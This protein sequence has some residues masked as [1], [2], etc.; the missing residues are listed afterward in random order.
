M[1][2]LPNIYFTEF[3]S[4]HHHNVTMSKCHNAM[5]AG[6]N[7]HHNVTNLCPKKENILLY[8]SIFSSSKHQSGVGSSKRAKTMKVGLMWS[9]L[10]PFIVCV[11]LKREIEARIC[12]TKLGLKT[13]LRIEV[14][15]F[16][17]QAKNQCVSWFETLLFPKTWSDFPTLRLALESLGKNGKVGFC[18][19]RTRYTFYTSRK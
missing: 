19:T 6:G 8:R 17:R 2:L 13:K 3:Y 11:Q 1:F 16:L 12:D 4:N 15:N 14:R 10:T 9:D 7:H 5:Y 18:S